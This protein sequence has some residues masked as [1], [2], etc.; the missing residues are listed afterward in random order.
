M[1]NQKKLKWPK[2]T[3]F[4]NYLIDQ[5]KIRS[6]MSSQVGQVYQEKLLTE[7][8][9]QILQIQKLVLETL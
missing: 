3:F 8:M 4:G 9:N 6:V 5:S 1:V 7:D 2:L